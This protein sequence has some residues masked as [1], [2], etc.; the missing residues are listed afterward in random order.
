M[1]I[2]I[3]IY[4]YTHTYDPP[5]CHLA[6]QGPSAG[7]QAPTARVSPVLPRP[8][9]GG[10]AFTVQAHPSP[11]GPSVGSPHRGTMRCGPI[12][13]DIASVDLGTCRQGR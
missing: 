10:S 3:Y 7:G 9:A 12:P 1:Y 4:I 5:M 11:P 2:Y 13:N 6:S 8:C